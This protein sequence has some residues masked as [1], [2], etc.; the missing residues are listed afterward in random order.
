MLK[1]LPTAPMQSRARRFRP[2]VP[3]EA[4]RNAGAGIALKTAHRMPTVLCRVRGSGHLRDSDRE[5]ITYSYVRVI[6]V[7]NA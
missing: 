5:G 3:K 2:G 1:C 7:I 4:P 6:N